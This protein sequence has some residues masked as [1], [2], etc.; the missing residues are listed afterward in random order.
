MKLLLE[1]SMRASVMACAVLA[2]RI[3]FKRLPKGMFYVLWILVFMRAALVFSFPAKISIWNADFFRNS[4]ESSAVQ[5]STFPESTIRLAALPQALPLDDAGMEETAVRKERWK[6]EAG[7]LL[8]AAWMAGVLLL[9][10]YELIAY[11]KLCRRVR[12]SVR[13]KREEALSC[14]VYQSDQIQTAFVLGMFRPRIYLPSDISEK[15]KKFLME[16]ELVHIRRHDHQIK[17]AACL[18]LAFHWF[19]PVMWMSFYFL[20]KDMELS[21][22]AQV[23]KRLG[24]DVRVDYSHTLLDL[25]EPFRFSSEF[26]PA[27]GRGNVKSRIWNIMSYR[28]MK[29]RTVLCSVLFV[30][31][32]VCGCMSNPAGEAAGDSME[33]GGG[34]ETETIVTEQEEGEEAAFARQFVEALTDTESAADADDVYAMLSPK[35]KERID[36]YPFGNEYQIR[37]DNGHYFRTYGKKILSDGMSAD[38]VQTEKGFRYQ[39]PTAGS[40][41]EEFVWT[42][43]IVLEEKEQG[44]GWQIAE[45]SDLVY[46]EL[47]SKEKYDK[48]LGAFKDISWD[49]TT[50]REWKEANPNEEEYPEYYDR[51]KDP[52]EALI[53]GLHLA[54]GTV[55]EVHEDSQTEE[56]FVT[57]KWKDGSITFRMIYQAEDGIYFP[58]GAS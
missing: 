48:H 3:C 13:A 50:L 2:A 39:I 56:A 28:P 53:Q 52:A 1:L 40:S 54:G 55:K 23:M 9:I 44:S 51:N 15:Q 12:F 22:D 18:I 31:V 57:Y 7:F 8:A 20:C 17:L 41:M 45:W 29:K 42:G 27:F 49:M 11:E 58:V 47:D 38:I 10:F 35:L 24:L 33:Q 32:F 46:V 43:E 19:N 4:R 30:L 21:C 36:T 14:P 25:A 16:H 34:L 6:P 26:F 5:E 37:K